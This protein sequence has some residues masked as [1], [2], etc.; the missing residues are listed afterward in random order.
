[1]APGFV[2]SVGCLSEGFLSIVWSLRKGLGSNVVPFVL[3]G[4]I[5]TIKDFPPALLD[6]E[7]ASSRADTPQ[8]NCDFTSHHDSCH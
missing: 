5:I 8:T 4:G 1:M 2:A 3:R 7:Q 6:P